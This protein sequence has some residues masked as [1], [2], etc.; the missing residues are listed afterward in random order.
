M[1]NRDQLIAVEGYPF[2]GL[3]AF[4]ALFCAALEWSFLAILFFALTLFS[5]YFFRNPE[6]VPPAGDEKIVAPAD[7]KIIFVGKVPESRY[8]EGNDVTKVS[9]F[10]N[11]FDVHINRVPISGRVIDQFYNPG[12]FFNASLDKA[13][14][15]NE[16]AGML[17]ETRTGQTILCVQIAGLVARRIVTY[18]E[19]GDEIERGQRYGLIRFGSR[20][21]L[22]LPEGVAVEA[23][24]GERTV[25]GETV[26]GS[27]S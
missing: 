20:V 26:L 11:V 2:I 24:V 3:F 4:I 9:I 7:G 15:E 10:M 14:L 6:R 19:I 5:I 18:A 22:Y 25:A 12:R 23:R 8:F 27:L 16:Q 13:S 17:I 1:K 21:D